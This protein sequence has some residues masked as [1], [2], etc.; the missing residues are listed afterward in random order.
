MITKIKRYAFSCRKVDKTTIKEICVVNDGRG[1]NES[2]SVLCGGKNA[3]FASWVNCL[4]ARGETRKSIS[5]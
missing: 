5:K 3:F 2:T 1:E 4:S